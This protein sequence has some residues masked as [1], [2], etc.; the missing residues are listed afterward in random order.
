MVLL[1]AHARS[2]FFN[3]LEQTPE[4]CGEFVAAACASNAELRQR[5]EQLLKFHRETGGIDDGFTSTSDT[6]DLLKGSPFLE[7]PGSVIGP[8]RLLEQIGEGGFGIVYLAEQ[9]HPVRRKVALKIIKPGMDTRLMIARFEAERQALA[10]MEHPN[11]AQVFDG[12]STPTGRPYFVMELVRGIPITEFCDQNQLPI[13]QRIELF[14]SVSKAVQHAHQKGIIHRDIKPSNVLV[15]MHDDKRVVKVIDFGIA[16]A[17]GQQLT[18]VTLFTNFAQMI[19]TPPYMSPEQTQLDGQDVDTRSD[20]YSMG[21][22]LY[23][24][25]TGTTPFDSARLGSVTFEEYRRIINEEQPP[26]PS[27]RLNR[28]DAATV[29]AAVQRGCDPRYLSHLI[30]GELDWLVMKCLE[31]DRNRRYETAN[32]LAL[33]LS[34]YLNHEPVQACPPS[35]YYRLSVFFRRHRAS[36]VTAGLLSAVALVGCVLTVWQAIQA[37]SARNDVIRAELDLTKTQEFAARSRA[38]AVAHDLETLNQANGLIDSGRSRVEVSEWAK[39][40]ADL[41]QALTLRPDHSSVWLTR[42]D[43]YAR[44]GLWDLAAADFQKAFALQEPG[45]ANSLLSHALLRLATRDDEGF[46]AICERMVKWIDDPADQK[47]WERNEAVRACLLREQQILFPDRLVF[48][49]QQAV[50]AGKS[51]VRLATLG[52]ALY[53]AGQFETAMECLQELK[54]ADPQFEPIWTDSVLAMI[55]YRLGQTESARERLQSATELRRRR[56]KQRSDASSAALNLQWRNELQSEIYLLEAT[57]LIEGREPK[58]V[59]WQ[60]KNRG[61][62]LAALGRLQDAAASFGRAIELAPDFYRAIVQRAAIY[63]KL[64]DWQNSLKDYELLQSLQPDNAAYNNE[65]AW[66]LCTCPDPRFRDHERAC[67]LAQKAVSH[68]PVQANH[69]NTLGVALYRNQDWEGAVKACLASM[70]GSNAQDMS[71]WLVIAM[72][73]WQLDHKNRAKQLLLHAIRRIS[74]GGN[75]S[76][77]LDEFRTEAIRLIGQPETSLMASVTGN[78]EDPDSYS[79]LLEIEPDR[80]WI[81]ALRGVAHARLKQWDQAVADFACVTEAQPTNSDYLYAEAVACIGGGDIERYRRVR[82]QILDLC[83]DSKAPGVVSHFCYISAVEPAT[84]EEAAA[85]LSLLEFAVS[86]TPRNPRI[87]GAMRYRAGQYEGSIA[88]LNQSALVLSRRG[89]D[90]LFLA[91][92]HHKLGQV[93]EAKMCL[94][95]AD[96]WIEQTNRMIARGSTNPWIGWYEQIEVEHLLKEARALIN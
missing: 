91:M 51:P 67:Q 50:D 39:G 22:L 15:A 69:C 48:L 30:R 72:C 84:P 26:K 25:L 16:K 59:P 55:R 7:G 24:L 88:D 86:E 8:Y 58:E 62:S 1:D 65:L 45:S 31:K 85:F 64:H 78:L 57:L 80:Y 9:L 90:W 71:D 96:E 12:G 17:V 28:S 32:S 35:L 41:S 54:L 63:L 40:E 87:R 81:V 92:A 76:E 53:R 74:H 18:E 70:Q 68:V 56:F 34:H 82:R 14:I 37:A 3:A 21:V 5:V 23:Q 49:S 77:Y 89:W 4:E 73:E 79:T 52:T 93:Q 36:V 75:Q 19:G 60:W 66:R 61:D 95:K 27:T 29:E 6:S 46:R 94:K 20:I 33:D 47:A 11:I 44:L 2:I 42:G 43:I 13:R 38:N 10:L 83:R